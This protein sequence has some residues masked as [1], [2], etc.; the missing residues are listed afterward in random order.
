MSQPTNDLQTW[1]AVRMNDSVRPALGYIS[2]LKRRMKKRGFT[3]E[4]GNVA[5]Y[6]DDQAS[7]SR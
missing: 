7:G 2:R 3:P 1:Q 5:L 4:D 6:N